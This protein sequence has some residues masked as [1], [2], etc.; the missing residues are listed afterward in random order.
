MDYGNYLKCENCGATGPDECDSFYAMEAWN[1]PRKR[2]AELEQL[3]KEWEES[4]IKSVQELA[5]FQDREIYLS[6]VIEQTRKE[7]YN[8]GMERAA[9]IVVEPV[10]LSAGHEHDNLLLANRALAIRKELE[11]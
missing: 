2:I 8:A 9:E 11:K 7:R 6:N 4:S 5:Y 1:K 10:I 3:N